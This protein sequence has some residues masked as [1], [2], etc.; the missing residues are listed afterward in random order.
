[1][2]VVDAA[3]GELVHLV[4]TGVLPVSAV[5]SEDGTEAWVSKFG[6]AKPTSRDRAAAQCCDP[7][8]S[9]CAWTSAASPRPGAVSRIDPVSGRVTATVE[10][11]RHPTGIGVGRGAARLYVADGNSDRVSIVDTREAR[12][13]ET[14]E[15]APFAERRIGLAPT[16]LALSPDGATLYVALGGANAVAVY[17]VSAGAPV[18]ASWRG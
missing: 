4:E 2:A 13:V 16:A 6:G 8:P 3:T 10:V 11:G 18:P 7:R 15:M 5:V 14:L 1:M 17:D 12:L 9:P